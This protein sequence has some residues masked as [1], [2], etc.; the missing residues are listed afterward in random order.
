MR[1]EF[2]VLHALRLK[3]LASAD[4]IGTAWGVSC[5]AAEL[6]R[7]A[8]AGLLQFRDTPRASGYLL[9]AAGRRL[10]ESLL[11]DL[12]A[13]LGREALHSLS[14]VYKRFSI[15]NE[16]FKALCTRWQMRGE[17][18]NDH[19]DPEYDDACI[20]E[21]AE[22]H[23]RFLPLVIRAGKAVPHFER[24]TPRFRSAL[25][26]LEDGDRDYFTKPLVDS[27]HTVWFE[28]HEDLIGTLGQKRQPHET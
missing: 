14:D 17:A 19:S 7:L 4:A 25:R 8:E 10:Y 6:E 2:L 26:L 1:E 23:G 28:F 13:A 20:C 22:L 9:L 12:R 15:V 3:G 5:A 24:Y 21:L 16:D 11:D 18:L 27:Y